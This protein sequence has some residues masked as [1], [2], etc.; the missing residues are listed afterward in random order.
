[1]KIKAIALI[2]FLSFTLLA[3]RRIG[4]SNIAVPVPPDP[5]ELVT[6]Q[7]SIPSAGERGADMELLQRA[8]QNSRLMNAGLGPSRIDV[9]FTA[10]GAGAASGQGQFTQIWLSPRAWRWS[11]T[12]G[13]TTVVRGASSQGPYADSDNAVPMPIHMLRNAIFSSMY[14][15]AI[16]TQL[17]AA[18]AA[19]NGKPVTCLLTSGVV[20]TARYQGRLW[21]ELEYCF[22]NASGLLVS[23]SF[24]PGVFTVYSYAQGQTLHGHTLPDHFTMYE[25]GRQVLDAALRLSDA[26]GTDP[27]TLAPEAGM[28]PRASA[29]TMP[30]RQPLA[31]PAPAGIT[32]VSPVIVHANVI[33]GRVIDAQICAASDPALDSTAL[34]TVKALSIGGPGQHQIYLNLKFDPPQN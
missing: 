8:L 15:L 25:G 2:T 29:L 28:V 17:R 16:G 6:G 23:S 31:F 11:A 7:V 24:A 34:N 21:E 3:Q 9:A 12:L 19:L 1:V 5:H 27:G 22:D 33:D 4:Q 14:D 20:G 32:N 30:T 13:A 10:T 26:T 18:P